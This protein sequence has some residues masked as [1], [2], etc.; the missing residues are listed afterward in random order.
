MLKNV[1]SEPFVKGK[2]FDKKKFDQKSFDQMRVTQKPF[3]SKKS[4]KIRL[5][6]KLIYKTDYP[7]QSSHPLYTEENHTKS[8]FILKSSHNNN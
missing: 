1:I 5:A 6:M 8:N 2:N 3:L 4:N 7:T